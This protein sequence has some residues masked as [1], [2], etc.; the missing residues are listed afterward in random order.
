M[1]V[2]RVQLVHEPD[3][4]EYALAV[5]RRLALPHA[6]FEIDARPVL[7]A[8]DDLDVAV[9]AVVSPNA[10]QQPTM[11]NTHVSYIAYA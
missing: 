3:V 5:R 8:F 10:A 6:L 2:D 4:G 1:F 9:P 7:R 11:L